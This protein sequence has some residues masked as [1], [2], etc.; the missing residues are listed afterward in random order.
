MFYYHT[1]IILILLLHCVH[2]QLLL[3]I[4]SG[5]VTLQIANTLFN[6][7]EVERQNLQKSASDEPTRICRSKRRVVYCICRQNSWHL[8]ESSNRSQ[9]DK[10]QVVSR[11]NEWNEMW[12]RI[13]VDWI[14]FIA[15]PKRRKEGRKEGR[16]KERKKQEVMS[17][18][19]FLKV[20]M[21]LACEVSGV[22]KKQRK[23]EC[24]WEWNLEVT[25]LVSG[26]TG[27][28]TYATFGLSELV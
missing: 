17:E 28:V 4:R 1:R 26:G 10:K 19:V 5:R 23:H 3:F 16:K 2:F 7:S 15:T 25:H 21:Y 24:P 6:C 8:R 11:T 13:C 12:Q 22:Q 18:M 27:C 20:R 9:L 14:P